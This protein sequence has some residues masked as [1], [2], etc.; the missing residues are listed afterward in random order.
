MKIM[1]NKNEL[2]RLMGF[3][4]RFEECERISDNEYVIDFYDN[5]PPVT[6]DIV[7]EEDCIRIDGAGILAY[8]DSMDGYY[9]AEAIDD[10][11]TINKIFKECGAYCE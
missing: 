2:A 6:L 7:F 5:Q 3:L 10:T 4:D 11:E 1:L 8:D 9:I